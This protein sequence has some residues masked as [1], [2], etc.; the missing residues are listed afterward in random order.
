[1]QL[2][3]TFMIRYFAGFILSFVFALCFTPLM[4]RAALQ[5]GIVDHPDGKLKRHGDAIPYLGGVAVFAAFLVTLG[6][7]TNFED[8]ETLGLLLAGS[9]AL[10]VGLID[11]F[12]VLTPPQKMLGQTLAALVLVKSGTFIKLTF[13]PVYVAIP[14][15]VL[16]IVAVTNA[17]NIIDI[18]DG[19]AAGVAAV[20]AVSILAANYMAGRDSQAFFAAVLAGATVG[21][22]RHNFHPAK[23]FL[24]DA[25]S[26]FVGFMLA[27]LSMNAG[28]T[29]VHLLAVISP[30]FILGIPLFDL[31]L[32]MFIRWR[33]GIPITKGSP[34]HFA[35]RLRRFLSVRE[36]AIA[37][38][39]IGALLGGVA[40]LMSNIQLEWAVATMGG[41]MSLA[42]LSAY[43]LLKV[44]MR[45]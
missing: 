16:W 36:T 26:M 4:R 35:L 6:V 32:V 21:F 25:G 8:R 39:I 2:P 45:S 17:F 19:L 20:A 31:L 18:M 7:L 23:I 33:R 11:D 22:L 27:A 30:V 15:T 3:E 37:T 40:L 43:L 9:I 12:G 14:L 29:R 38:Y 28:Y 1:M 10:L 42:C 24:G 5:L 41:T 13:L 44:D 34:D